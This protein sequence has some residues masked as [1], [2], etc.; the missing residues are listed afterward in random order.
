M[1]D[2]I[3]DTRSIYWFPAGKPVLYHVRLEKN[4]DGRSKFKCPMQC[5]V[6]L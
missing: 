2:L 3:C 6:V 4:N 5:W 1:S